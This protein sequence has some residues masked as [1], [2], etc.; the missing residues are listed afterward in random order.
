MRAGFLIALCSTAFLSTAFWYVDT[1]HLCPVPIA[2][3]V[4]YVD[5]RFGL[6]APELQR[7]AAAAEGLWEEATGQELFVYD[8]TAE[9]T[10]NLIY[11]ERQ[12]LA[13]TEE[14]W[15]QRLDAAEAR[16]QGLFA[17]L[18]SFAARYES[19]EASYTTKRAQ[20]ESTLAAYNAEV[21]EYNREGGAPQETYER[22][23][24][25]AKSLGSEQ[26]SLETLERELSS[27]AQTLSELGATGNEDV[28]AYN[29]EVEEYNALFGDR[30]TF[31]Q[32]DFKRDRI[33]IYKFTD[34]AELERVLIHEFG[35]ALGIG[36][37]EDELA[38]MYYLMTEQKTTSQLT[39]ADKAAFAVS[40]GTLGTFPGRVRQHIRSFLAYIN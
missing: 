39:D 8:E 20:Y 17:E 21:E 38:A 26:Q 35:H 36:H 9:F 22:L 33:N 37:V 31:T 27:L 23:Q 7:L 30:H 25:T 16:Y 10:V 1:A 18:E 32:G 2:Y 6:S 13:S 28:A 3:R 19:L 34:T 40:C 14:A 4:G 29:A 11:D 5:E 24:A 15:R 12:Q